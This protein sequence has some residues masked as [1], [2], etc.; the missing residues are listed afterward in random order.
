MQI[1]LDDSIIKLK[2][3]FKEKKPII[4]IGGVAGSG[5]TTAGN[6]LLHELELDHKIGTGWIREILASTTT[7]KK[8]YELFVHSFKP[9]NERESPFEHFT[10]VSKVILPAIEK[11]IDR[12]KREGQ[13]LLIEGPMMIPGILKPEMYDLFICLQKPENDEEYLKALTT[14]THIKRKITLEDIP[15]N[16]Q[17]ENELLKICKE[18]N[19]LVVPFG[20]KEERNKII[21]KE[22]TNKFLGLK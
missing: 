11:C 21:I 18:L 6:F 3:L 20:S 7:K 8:N 4:I 9:V 15:P 13:S 5:K 10:K 17:I 2:S 19:I 14:N 1:D 22:L 12:A 16:T